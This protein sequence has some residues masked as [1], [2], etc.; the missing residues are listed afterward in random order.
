MFLVVAL[1]GGRTKEQW[2]SWVTDRV[3]RK[4]GYRDKTPTIL[5]RLYSEVRLK[6][7]EEAMSYQLDFYL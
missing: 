1:L 7:F 6:N 2:Y 3:R 4:Y 5:P